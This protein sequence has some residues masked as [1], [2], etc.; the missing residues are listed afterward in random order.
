[1]S[2]TDSQTPKNN[3]SKE[4]TNKEKVIIA[5][6]IGTIV[7]ACMILFGLDI[8]AGSVKYLIIGFVI[9]VLILGLVF[10]LITL[11]KEWIFTKL[12]G[13]SEGDIS[14]VSGAL[15]NIVKN[16]S[17]GNKQALERDIDTTMGKVSAWYIWMS[18]RRWV[19]GVF[20]ALFLGFAGLLGALLIYNQNKLIEKQ[21]YR[22]DQ[23]TYL[24]EAERR[25][26]LVYLFSN[27]MDAIS[28]EIEDD[29]G[30]KE[31]RDLSPQLMGRIIALSSRLKP[32]TY[33]EGDNLTKK[34]L[35]P[36]RGQLLISLVK[37]QLDSSSY[38]NIFENG[39]FEYADLEGADLDNAFLPYISL[40]N[41]NLKRI[42][43]H[44][45]Y[46]PDVYFKNSDMRRAMMEKVTIG[47]SEFSN[48]QMD[49]VILRYSTISGADFTDSSLRGADMLYSRIYWT[50][51]INCDLTHANFKR[52]NLKKSD[53]RGATLHSTNFTNAGLDSVKVGSIDWLHN[54]QDYQEDSIIGLSYILKNYVVDTTKYEDGNGVYYLLKN[55]HQ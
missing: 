41:A 42:G 18:Y 19:I 39:D 30:K 24:L 37:S 28:K 50:N 48:V 23:Q 8:L 46:L 51:F 43:L 45:T 11:N 10:L 16:V 17:T 29:I 38:I 14:D 40:N 32:Y 4:R 35:S 5:F 26:Q 52:A 44:Y 1:M 13:A 20:Y 53:L 7:S 25:G 21:N 36:E 3:L 12:L 49:S 9:I 2:N 33:L 54:M 6:F 55:K 15:K 31:K 27:I 47:R 22:L 34:P